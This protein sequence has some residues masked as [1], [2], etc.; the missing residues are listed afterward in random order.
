M[1][2]IPMIDHSSLFS[3]TPI[4]M[5]QPHSRMPSDG[6]SDF[7][8]LNGTPQQTHSNSFEGKS[9]KYGTKPCVFFM[10]NGYCKKGDHCTFSHDL[11]LF[12]SSQQNQ[13][14]FVS[15]DKLYRTKPCKYFFETGICRKGEH[16][17]FSHDLSLKE[18]YLNGEL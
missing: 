3:S 1:N 17:N 15:V 6:M 4:E 16:C 2:D 18:Q 8:G 5:K 14:T 11:H 12:S 7:F 10:Q 9:L 13:K